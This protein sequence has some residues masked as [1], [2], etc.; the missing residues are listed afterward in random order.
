MISNFTR[1]NSFFQSLSESN[2]DVTY[3]DFD[4]EINNLVD[5][6]NRKV[7][8]SINNIGA[9]SYNGVIDNVNYVIRNIGDGQIVFDSIKD[10]NYQ[11]N[12]ISFVKI[13]NNISPFSLLF[14]NSASEIMAHSIKY[15]NLGIGGIFSNFNKYYF[16]NYASGLKIE[17]KNFYDKAILSNNIELNTITSD[18]VN[19]D[20]KEY[21][22]NNIT[23][24]SRHIVNNSIGNNEFAQYSISYDKLHSD[25]KN[26]RERADIFLVYQN[27]SI[28]ADK[29]KDNSFDFRL[30]STN[31]DK[32]GKGIL[33]KAVVPLNSVVIAKPDQY[34]GET[35]DTYKLC[36]YSIANAYQLNTYQ[37]PQPDKVYVNPAYIEKLNLYNNVSKQLTDA[38]NYLNQLYN[39][40]IAVGNFISIDNFNK[41]KGPSGENLRY[42][43]SYWDLNYSTFYQRALNYQAQQE[44]YN[45][46]YAYLIN[47]NN[48]L[49]KIPK[50]IYTPV[51]PV[52]Y[53]KLEAVPNTKSYKR[54]ANQW[55]IKSKHLKNNTFSIINIPDR[56]NY[57]NVPSNN[58]INKYALDINLQRK[59]GLV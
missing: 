14:V 28:S 36:I 2:N 1:D 30:I 32:F 31:L 3:K 51:P 20:G 24:E 8:T 59:L 27:N 15:D 39:L 47:I 16:Y 54:N 9:K 44:T 40:C 12:G 46:L 38:Q 19:N 37:D 11:N 25:I 56:I 29:V 33:H 10:I 35:I 34:A 22:V 48:D 21:L 52:I 49:Q 50:N 58:F 55:S 57:N 5:Y 18:H 42:F 4:N 6:L 41:N 23:I 53:Q 26:F 17:G 43:F 13:D 45:N 7:V